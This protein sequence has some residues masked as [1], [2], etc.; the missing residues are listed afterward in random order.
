MP[1]LS[2]GVSV[3]SPASLEL[4]GLLTKGAVASASPSGSWVGRSLPRLGMEMVCLA[5]TEAVEGLGAGQARHVLGFFGKEEV[6]ES[7]LQQAPA[8]WGMVSPA[9]GWPALGVGNCAS[10]L[11]Q[12]GRAELVTEGH[13]VQGLAW[14]HRE[15]DPS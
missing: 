12:N 9:V 3:P 2:P 14:R 7:R 4:V 13:T 6:L 1:T 15:G 10:R 11:A 5:R 8:G